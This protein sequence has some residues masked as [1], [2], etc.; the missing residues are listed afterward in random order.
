MFGREHLAG[1][2][3]T[4]LHF[5]G[6]EHDAMLGGELAEAMQERWRRNDVASFALDGFHHDRRDL[7]R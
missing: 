2:A 6:N 1:A 7:V 5:V 3:H 4:G